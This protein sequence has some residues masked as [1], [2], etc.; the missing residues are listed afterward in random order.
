MCSVVIKS[1]YQFLLVGHGAALMRRETYYAIVRQ[2]FPI[3]T[4]QA[5]PSTRLDL[6]Q[7][8]ALP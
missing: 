3:M 4:Q 2:R 8:N 6:P 7:L 5:L 1:D